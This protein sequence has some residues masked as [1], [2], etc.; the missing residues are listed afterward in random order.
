MVN[1]ENDEQTLWPLTWEAVEEAQLR[2][3][4]RLT[5]AQ[6]LASAEALLEFIQM[7]SA[8]KVDERDAGTAAQENSCKPSTPRSKP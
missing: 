1:S 8:R 3:N 2:D 4:L 6:R 7:A 5:P